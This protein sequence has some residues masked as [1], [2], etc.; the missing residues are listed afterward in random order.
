VAGFQVTT[1]GRFWVI[2]KALRNQL[3]FHFEAEAIMKQFQTPG[4]E[5]RILKPIFITGMGTSNSQV[6]YEL[7]DVCALSALFDST[8][9]DSA[10]EK[11]IVEVV[12]SFTKE[13]DIFM[14]AALTEYG[15]HCELASS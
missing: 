2:A 15:W 3:V 5:K 10:L 14:L 7:S 4:L 13:A 9:T 6:H 12:E 8:D 1:S 11:K